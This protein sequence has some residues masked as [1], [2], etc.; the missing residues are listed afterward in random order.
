MWPTRCCQYSGLISPT[1]SW[2]RTHDQ[3]EQVEQEP[4]DVAQWTPPS[5]APLAEFLN[6]LGVTSRRHRQIKEYALIDAGPSQRN[7]E[8]HR[9][10]IL[11]AP[12]RRRLVNAT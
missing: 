12:A 7:D 2:K 8:H 9:A 11:V 6:S 10:D 4:N 1:G 5:K 3:E